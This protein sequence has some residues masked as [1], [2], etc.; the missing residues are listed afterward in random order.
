MMHVSA[1]GQRSTAR[2][3]SNADMHDRRAHSGSCAPP[4]P[5]AYSGGQSHSWHAPR[6]APP[7]ALH[8]GSSGHLEHAGLA[9]LGPCCK[10]AGVLAA[11]CDLLRSPLPPHASISL[12]TTPAAAALPPQE[13]QVVACLAVDHALLLASPCTK[14][15]WCQPVTRSKACLIPYPLSLIA[16]PV[17]QGHTHCPHQGRQNPSVNNGLTCLI[18]A[19][20]HPS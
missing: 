3:P 4:L 11:R 5:T 20:M 8:V 2:P 7:A 14:S 10:A 16:Y 13:W 12:T 18:A 6:A 19:A 15:G 17:S 1:A 9:W